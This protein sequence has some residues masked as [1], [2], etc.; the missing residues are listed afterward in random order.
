MENLSEFELWKQGAE[1]KVYLG[2]FF[3]Q[4]VIVKERFPKK[5]RHPAL[6]QNL[7][8]DRFKSEA[9]MLVRCKAAGIK[10]PTVYYADYISCRLCLEY[11]PG[12][13][14]AKDFI[15][16]KLLMND[17]RSR[18]LLNKLMA[19]IGSNVARLHDNDI[20]HGDLTT[21]NLILREPHDDLDLYFIDFGLGYVSKSPED[22]SVDLYVLERAFLSTH[23]GTEEL[24]ALLLRTYLD[25]STRDGKEIAAKFY[26]V[27]LRGRK[28][29]MIG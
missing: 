25:K 1:A 13:A 28:R 19:L 7:T 23:P 27:R 22:K 11:F 21:S 4:P 2:D 12:S 29:V 24:F 8:Q 15:N 14:T 17:E 16:E 5:Y 6:D 9:R 26:E 20:I 10:T 3:G 18:D